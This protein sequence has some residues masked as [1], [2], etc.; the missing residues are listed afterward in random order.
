[1]PRNLENRRLYHRQYMREWYARNRAV[2]IARARR[3]T[4]RHRNLVRMLIAEARAVPCLDCKR[5]FPIECMDFDHVR[6][7]KVAALA[8]AMN[9]GWSLDRVR[10][11][12]AKCEVVCANCHRIRTKYRREITRGAAA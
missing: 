4:E 1:M 11:E 10:D 12:I 8:R 6:G 7:Q 3:A 2:H 5:T 9:L